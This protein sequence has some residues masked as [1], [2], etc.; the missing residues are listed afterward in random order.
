MA[1]SGG[2]AFAMDVVVFGLLESGCQI[3]QFS[4]GGATIT[5]APPGSL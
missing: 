3:G 5:D 1:M 2:I 4:I